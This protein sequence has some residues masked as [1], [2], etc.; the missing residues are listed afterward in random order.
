MGTN[1]KRKNF[2]D[3]DIFDDNI[4]EKI[5]ELYKK[6][7]QIE[8]I[9]KNTP[10]SDNEILRRINEYYAEF[11]TWDTAINR[12]VETDTYKCLEGEKD[13]NNGINPFNRKYMSKRDNTKYTILSLKSQMSKMNS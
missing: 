12:F 10:G 13:K 6:T 3:D 9:N 8:E 2:I 7:R 11:G 1:D 4:E 5:D